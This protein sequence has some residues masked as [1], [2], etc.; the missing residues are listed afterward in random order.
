MFDRIRALFGK[1]RTAEDDV[2]PDADV[3]RT[4]EAGGR[5]TERGDSGSTTGVGRSEEFV[6]R[7]AGQ[8]EGF[9]GETGAEIR[10]EGSA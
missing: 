2:R 1:P 5:D 4:R 8:D 3:A 9:A 10:R 7:A 6:G